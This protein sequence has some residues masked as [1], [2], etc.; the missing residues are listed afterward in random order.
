MSDFTETANATF[1]INCPLETLFIPN[2]CITPQLMKSTSR[3]REHF[4]KSR[5]SSSVLQISTA[6]RTETERTDTFARQLTDNNSRPPMAWDLSV[7]Q[8]EK[9]TWN[10]LRMWTASTKL[11]SILL[12]MPRVMI[13]RLFFSGEK[14]FKLHSP[15]K[16]ATA[17]D[18][19]N[20][21]LS[22]WDTVLYGSGSCSQ[23][24]NW[25]LETRH[26]CP[27]SKC[28]HSIGLMYLG[29]KMTV[30]CVR[31]PTIFYESP[32]RLLLFSL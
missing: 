22:F 20:L 1:D 5:D 24:S 10:T 31:A 21:S 7:V 8:G 19:N 16:I 14:M 27:H 15:T 23:I 6:I 4:Y 28:F 9:V 26:D 17:V 30:C 13:S 25:P 18:P 32:W 3:W 2:G 29:L 11:T 12:T